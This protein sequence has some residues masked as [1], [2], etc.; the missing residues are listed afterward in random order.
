MFRVLRSKGRV[1]TSFIM[2]KK[3]GEG[4]GVQN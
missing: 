3:F 4:D 2:A 1:L